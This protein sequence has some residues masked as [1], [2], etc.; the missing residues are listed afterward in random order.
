M[1]KV[2]LFIALVSV[3]A[4]CSPEELKTIFESRNAQLTIKV[5]KV[6]NAVDNK[7][8]TAVATKDPDYV[9]PGNPDIK[10][11]THTVMASYGGV[12]GSI[13]VQYPDILADTDPVT[14]TAGD[15]W[16]PGTK[17]NYKIEVKAGKVETKTE[18]FGLLKAQKEGHSYNGGYWLEN[19]TEYILVDTYT[20]PV[21]SG[22]E[23]VETKIID[24]FFKDD[25]QEKFDLVK[26]DKITSE[27]TV[28][29][30]FVSAWAYYNVINTVTTTTTTYN[31]VAT[32]DPAGSAAV[33][34]DNGV[35]GY[36]KKAS[37]SSAP[38][39]VEIA[40]PSHVSHYVEPAAGHDA[41]GHGTYHGSHGDG[42]NAGG[43][44]ADAE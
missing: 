6:Y 27:D 32:P 39:K 14:I 10:A 38:K 5:G 21:Y 29:E 1:K 16:L 19:A 12:S 4:A 15:I 3:F 24:E 17:N 42:S 36:Y 13:D 22:S 34:G 43:G 31:I 35:I 41:T 23:V 8:L 11:G 30:A 20:Y 2:F 26:N 9:I 33:P 25:I 40:H 18:E 7:D 28:G 44:F 37:K